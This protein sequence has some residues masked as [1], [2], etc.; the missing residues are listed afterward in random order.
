MNEV[1]WMNWVNGMHAVNWMYKESPL[2]NR[3]VD[4]HAFSESGGKAPARIFWSLKLGKH[5]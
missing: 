1:K 5:H 2:M 4:F 3:N